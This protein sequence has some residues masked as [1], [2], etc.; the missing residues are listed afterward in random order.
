MSDTPDCIISGMN[1]HR[2]RTSNVFYQQIPVASLPHMKASIKS[3]AGF[4]PIVVRNYW[5]K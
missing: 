3:P 1:R 2:G 5:F 4:K